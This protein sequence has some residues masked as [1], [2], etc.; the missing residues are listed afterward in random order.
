MARYNDD[1]IFEVIDR[2]G[3]P[4][5]EEDAFSEQEDFVVIEYRGPDLADDP[6]A[7]DD[8]RKSKKE[9][10]R[11]EEERMEAE[12]REREKEELK[13]EILA[14][15]RAGKKAAIED[16]TDGG[17]SNR[18]ERRRA[19]KETQK[20]EAPNETAVQGETEEDVPHQRS[21]FSEWMMTVLSGNILSKA[22]VKRTYP[23]LLF[24]AFL[25]FLYIGNVFRMQQLYRKQESLRTEVKELR[26]KS[27][28]IASE[29]MNATRQSNIIAEI[30]RRGLPLKESLTPSEVIEK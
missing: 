26:A 5:Q 20:E 17:L 4:V 9:R 13:K 8:R 30:E 11:E 1:D 6:M 12:R 21:K 15:L 7:Q 25:A 3:E 2:R 27:L 16:E 28:T 22:E 29:R 23:Y 10:R 14:E 19:G 18:R 24:I